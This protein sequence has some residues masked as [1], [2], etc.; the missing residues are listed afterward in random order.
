MPVRRIATVC[1]LLCLLLLAGCGLPGAPQ[2]PSL[3]L[4][5]PVTDLHAQREGN[6]V[7]LTWTP[8]RESTD[9]VRLSGS[10]VTRICRTEIPTLPAADARIPPPAACR[11]VG[12]ATA[13]P[14]HN[15]SKESQDFT[16]TLPATL[17]HPDAS[18]AVYA[19]EVQNSA[20]RSG[21]LSNTA[22]VPLALLPAP[23][24][25]LESQLNAEGPAIGWT[26]P[27]D[28]MATLL[29]ESAAARR[30]ISYHYRLDRTEKGAKPEAP[31]VVP[32][33][34]AVATPRLAQPNMLVRD[35][36]AEWEKTYDYTL[37]LVA[38]VQPPGATAGTT[39]EIA[40]APSPQLEVFVHDTFPPAVPTGVQAVFS[41]VNTQRFID[42]TW[43]ANT[44]S[45]LAGYDLYRRDAAASGTPQKVNQELI[46]APA[47]RDSN[48]E[49][50]RTYLY[51]VVAVDIR[52]NRSAPSAEASETVPVQP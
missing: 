40:S 35:T 25:K 17:E 36:T 26:I 41:A 48:V 46:K 52:G 49:P 31:T 29:P 2:P 14:I 11:E 42:L 10:L 20:G 21:G 7:H 22:I 9:R 5:R 28:Q 18:G 1:A 33:M 47:F 27:G 32:I 12:K 6:Q 15:G 24:Q 8:P 13:P 3:H 23:P 19:I 39:W 4:P 44:D 43:H 34:G 37:R 45:D 30:P 38:T 50:G 51:S 16:D